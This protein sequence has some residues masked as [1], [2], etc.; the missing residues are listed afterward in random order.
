MNPS[1]TSILSSLL[2]T[3]LIRTIQAY[4]PNALQ[5][6]SLSFVP[7]AIPSSIPSWLSSNGPMYNSIT[8]SKYITVSVTYHTAKSNTLWWSLYNLP[9][10]IQSLVSGVIPSS[11]PTGLP[12]DGQSMS[13]SQIPRIL[14]TWLPI[15]FTSTIPSYD[16]SV[17]CHHIV[18]H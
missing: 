10:Y 16:P 12:S 6:H 7:K 11:L 18:H 15:I 4:D 2:Y 14:Q 3:I 8:D 1:Q 5:L 9:S 13:P 17:F